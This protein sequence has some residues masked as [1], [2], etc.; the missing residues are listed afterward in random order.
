MVTPFDGLPD[1]PLSLKPE[2]LSVK[3]AI[4]RRLSWS[5]YQLR[6]ALPG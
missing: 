2:M 3:A 6:L 4:S 1:D 5:G